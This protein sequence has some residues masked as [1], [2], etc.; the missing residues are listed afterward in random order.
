[1]ARKDAALVEPLKPE[2]PRQLGAYWLAGRV[3]EG[4]YGVVFEGYDP[5]GARVAVKMLKGGTTAEA[6][7]ELRMLI[8]VDQ[9]CTARVIAADFDHSPAY[10]VSE[11][12][13]GPDLKSWIQVNGPYGPAAVY[14]LGRD[15]ARALAPIHRVGITHRDLKPANILLEPDGPKVID[16]GLARAQDM[17]LSANQIKGTPLYMAPEVWRN[18]PA[19]PAVDVW[20]WGAIVLFAATGHDS[21]RGENIYA[22]RHQIINAD[23][24]FEAL[25]EPL[26]SLVAQALSK[27]PQQRP[28]ADQLM[29][30]LTETMPP[31]G[32]PEP[33]LLPAEAVAQSAAQ[34]AELTYAHLSKEEQAVVPSMLLRMVTGSTDPKDALRTAKFAE[35]QN[36]EAHDSDTHVQTIGRVLDRLCSDGAVVRNGDGYTLAAPALLRGWSRLG[37]WVEEDRPVLGLHH[38]LAAAARRWQEHGRKDGDLLQGSPLDLAVEQAA[39]VQHHLKLNHLERDYYDRSIAAVRRRSRVRAAATATLAVLL[40]IAIAAAVT[41]V[42]QSRAVAAQRDRAVGARAANVAA[43]MRRTDPVIAKQLGVAAAALAPEAIETRS[44]LLMLHNQPEQFTYVPPGVDGTWKS[45]G[46]GTGHVVVYAKGQDVKVVDVDARKVTVS[47]T[48]PGQL[49][50]AVRLTDDGRIAA[51]MSNNG[52]TSLW[53]TTTGKPWPSPLR[54]ESWTMFLSPRG[55][56]LGTGGDVR[57]NKGKDVMSLRD[58]KTGRRVLKIPHLATYT[59]MSV[60]ETMLYLIND[61]WFEQW[62]I[63]TGKR[64]VRLEGKIPFTGLDVSPDGRVVAL[65]QKEHLLL[66]RDGKHTKIPTLRIPTAYRSG[67]GNVDFSSDGRYVA[68]DGAVFDAGSLLSMKAGGYAGSGIMSPVSAMKPFSRSGRYCR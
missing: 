47:F 53:D 30:A 34:K 11:F 41:A 46:D 21:F 61:K 32:T 44:T 65:R 26:R 36:A 12:I 48:V 20:A 50:W 62:D 45:N 27:D 52:K 6:L 63:S 64:V 58:V 3:G 16:F 14:R 42:D 28:T 4:S 33:E 15:L 13:A 23:P 55:T 54:T 2:D 31:A 17:T 37:A 10:V 40:V 25:T 24:S 59:A 19:T 57:G 35:F 68:V 29:A 66:L 38:N 43:A 22:V 39:A 5:A 51:L 18:D 60:D 49:L 8:R 56:Y 9:S 67:Q 7:R 1:M